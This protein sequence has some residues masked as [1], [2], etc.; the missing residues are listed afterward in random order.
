VLNL[1]KEYKTTL[2]YVISTEPQLW[3]Y[4]NARIGNQMG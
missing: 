3:N 4:V 1:A 2:A